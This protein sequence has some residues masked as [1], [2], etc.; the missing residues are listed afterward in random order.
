MSVSINLYIGPYMV[1]PK[2]NGLSKDEWKSCLNTACKCK[3]HTKDN[4]C[5]ECGDKITIQSKLIP[6]KIT[7]GKFDEKFENWSD[8]LYAPHDGGSEISKENDY[9]ISND[10]DKNLNIKAVDS[11][12]SVDYN[13]QDVNMSN[14]INNFK[15]KFQK[16][17]DAVVEDGGK[18]EFYY[19]L[20]VHYS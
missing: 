4:Y 11:Y 8:E 13:L 19:G 16:Y 5:P 12:N 9:Y 15:I 7:P 17:I 18:P 10:N 2:I 6:C 1:V 14:A 20:F 3:K